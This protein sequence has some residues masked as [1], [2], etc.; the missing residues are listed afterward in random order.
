MG[1]RGENILIRRNLVCSLLKRLSFLILE[2]HFKTFFQQFWFFSSLSWFQYE[3]LPY[4][5]QKFR[6]SRQKCILRVQTNLRWKIGF[7]LEN[8]KV[9][10]KFSDSTQ[11]MSDFGEKIRHVPGHRF[12][13]TSARFEK[14]NN[15]FKKKHVSFIIMG[16]RVESKKNWLLTIFCPHFCRNFILILQNNNLTFLE[17]FLSPYPFWDPSKNCWDILCKNFGT[18]VEAALYVYRQTIW[19]ETIFSKEHS[20]SYLFVTWRGKNMTS[21][22]LVSALLTRLRFSVLGLNFEIFFLQF[23][24]FLYFLGF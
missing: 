24:I 1:L 8:V 20:S 21:D 17:Q 3:L 4:S 2:L 18:F 19:G 11:K 5:A 13:Y 9:F 16:L 6:H 12:S 14:K 23:S 10:H 7:R 22:N 15:C